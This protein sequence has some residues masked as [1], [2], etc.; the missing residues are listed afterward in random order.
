[1][2]TEQ[3]NESIRD[4]KRI[5]I[6]G[7]TFNPIHNG[8]LVIAENARE[9]YSLDQVMFIPTGH[10][11]LRHKQ[12]ITDAVHRCEMV[13]L[14]IADNPWFVLNQI[15]IQSSETSYTF[16]TIEKLKQNYKNSDLYF[17][18]GAD[19][20]F[21]FQTWKNP[22]LILRNCKILAAYRK[23]QR[24]EE[25]FQYIAYLNKKY[26]DKFY[27]LDTPSLE[28]SSQEI[29]RRTQERQTIRYLVPKEVEAYIRKNKLYFE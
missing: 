21:D 24:Q 22:D 19:S 7:G 18:L 1:M 26:P 11:P 23:H 8:H 27:P 4:A 17:I 20:L 5:G 9:Q 16:L 13:S 14:A 10:S 28:V 12:Q 29:R 6:M 2:E 25:F 15:E 3:K